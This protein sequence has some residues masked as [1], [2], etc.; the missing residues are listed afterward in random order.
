MKNYKQNYELY[1]VTKFSGIKEMLDIAVGEA[2]ENIAFKY[3]D[4]HG[5]IVSVTYS[6]FKDT[7]VY[8]GSALAELGVAS[9]HIACIGENSYKW[10]TAYLTVLISDGVFVPIDRELPK[11]DIINIINSSDSEVIF[12]DNKY[13]D[14]FKEN[15]DKLKS[16]KYFISFSRDEHEDNFLSYHRLVERGKELADSGY[17][18]Y[19]TMQSDP[20]A[21]KLL[22]YTSGTTGNAKGVMLSEHNIVSCVYYGLQVSTVFDTC[23]SVLPYHHTYEAVA[24]ILVGLHKHVTIC[25]NDSLKN[26]AKN[27]KLYSP[28]YIYLVPAFAELFYK[29]IHST[30]VQTGKETVFNALVSVSNALRKIGIDIRRKLFK[31]IHENFGGK[32]EK[33][34]CGGA[35]LSQKVGK[36]F[37][38]I[39]INIINGYGITECSPLVS[40]NRDYFNDFTTTGMPLPCAR[41][42]FEDIAEDGNGEICVK[43]DIVMMGYYKNPEETARVLKDGWF[44]TG[45]YGR[46]N[47][48]G[49]LIITGRKKNLI[50]LKNGKNVYPEEIEEYIIEIP[51]VAEVIVYAKKDADGFDASLCAELYLSEEEVAKLEID[52]PY[53]RVKADIAAVCEEL[54]SYKKI[55]KVI[56]RE[57]EFEKT[58]SRKIKRNYN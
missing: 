33:M 36:F 7:T 39:G 5:G 13:D 43:G 26:V 34:V 54:P 42:K 45:D 38:D 29:K 21:L 37:D 3:G 11:N 44:Y 25:I 17:D 51:Y 6:E 31:T 16:I 8:I 52:D 27:I 35:P 9:G 24:G 40:A 12:Y 55:S 53:E 23:L 22:V 18:K 4:G 57:T 28:A 58:T 48:K 56:V 30:L 46:L 32:L 50:V 20:S 10:L 49:Q 14:I 15:I 41:L 2:G 19:K 47:K 1:P